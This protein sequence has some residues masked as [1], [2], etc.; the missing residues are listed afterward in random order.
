MIELTI[1][2][3]NNGATV[4]VE[5]FTDLHQLRENLANTADFEY[6]YDVMHAL[7]CGAST[8]TVNNGRYTVDTYTVLPE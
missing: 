6:G 7:E 2:D 3:P 8:V 4:D 1:K 5:H